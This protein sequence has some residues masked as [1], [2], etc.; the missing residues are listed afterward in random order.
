MCAAPLDGTPPARAPSGEHESRLAVGTIAQQL[1]HVFATATMLTVLT[2]LARELT[3]AEFGTYGLLVSLST[4]L[5]LAQTSVEGA[6]VKAL[7][8]VT[9]EPGRRQAFTTAVFLYTVIGVAAAFVVTGLGILVLPVLNVPEDLLREARLGLVA[10]GAA[11]CLG[12]PLKTYHDVLRGHQLFRTAALAELIAYAFF[13][14]ASLALVWGGAPLWMLIGIGGAIPLLI[15]VAASVLVFAR[16]IGYRP[17]PSSVTRESVRSFLGL[18]TSLLA[19]GVADLLIYGLDRMILSG[20]RSVTSVALYEGPVRAHNLVRLLHGT[21]VTTVLP[22]TARFLQEGDTQRVRDLLIRGTR[23]VLAATVPL[24]VVLIVLAG[25]ILDVWLGPEFVSGQ[26]ALAILVGYWLVGVNTGVAGAMLVAAGRVRRLAQ[27][28]WLVAA[29]N[30]VLAL[31]LTPEFGL[32][33]VVLATAIPYVAFFPLF[34]A[35]TLRTF[36]VTLGELAREAWLPAY[37]GA[38]VLAACLVGLRAAVTV[39][40]VGEVVGAALT[41]MFAYWLAYY[42]LWLRPNERGL[43]KNLAFGALRRG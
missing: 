15:G 1:V 33:G 5:L 43:V 12:W 25:P 16:R 27:Y 22:A 38:L 26:D 10:I 17:Y 23:Y 24:V 3:L 7:A 4:Y 8:E 6:A 11:M 41:G 32:N 14:A 40:T 36:P 31:A 19:I 21:L 28:A 42:A 2:V 29:A 37:T 13:G 39:D 35:L 30:L 18:S 9:D 20:F 34:L